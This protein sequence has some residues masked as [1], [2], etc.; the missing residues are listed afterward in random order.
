MKKSAEK[1]KVSQ[2]FVIALSIVSIVGFLSI[3]SETM[4]NFSLDTYLDFILMLVVGGGLLIDADLKTLKGL[5]RGLTPKKFTHLVVAV[6]GALA[7]I[8]GIFSLPQISFEHPVFLAIKGVIA[9]IAI[10]VIIIQ[11]W[12]GQR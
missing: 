4:L 11:T 9:I 5:K 10:I 12:F 3:V 2:K 8:A 7:V 6:I 1:K